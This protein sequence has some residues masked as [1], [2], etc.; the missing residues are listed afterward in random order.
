MHYFHSSGERF[1][2]SR[3]FSCMLR[4]TERR[5]I[6]KLW[7]VSLVG[8]SNCWLFYVPPGSLGSAQ[9]QDFDIKRY[10]DHF[11]HSYGKSPKQIM[12]IADNADFFEKM[13]RSAQTCP[14][15]PQGQP[16]ST[17][18]LSRLNYCA[19]SCHQRNS[20][21]GTTPQKRTVASRSSD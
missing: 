4:I 12:Y 9:R 3:M 16:E 13:S 7:L 11:G 1:R 14:H 19:L 10:C 6:D 2:T 18:R 5:I 17:S 15:C 20:R 8:V 21:G